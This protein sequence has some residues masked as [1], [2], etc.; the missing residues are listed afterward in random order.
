MKTRYLQ[1]FF[2]TSTKFG[3]TIFQKNFH[4]E[5]QIFFGCIKSKE[6]FF[7]SVIRFQ[8]RDP[9]EELRLDIQNTVFWK[10]LT[11]KFKISFKGIGL[12]HG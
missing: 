12:F 8:E 4:F 5:L 7:S 1:D 10:K 9:V 3:K 11:K 2:Q 6:I